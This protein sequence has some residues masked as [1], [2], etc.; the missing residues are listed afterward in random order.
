MISWASPLTLL[1][2]GCWML[3]DP[4][5]WPLH[6]LL[7]QICLCV[8][9]TARWDRGRLPDFTT[10][11]NK[12]ELQRSSVWLNG[13]WCCAAVTHHFPRASP[14]SL[15]SQSSDCDCISHA[16][17][18]STFSSID[19]CINWFP[20][21][22]THPLGHSKAGAQPKWQRIVHYRQTHTQIRY[23]YHGGDT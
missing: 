21:V 14:G 12:L 18:G 16:K 15:L 8:S 13:R 3:A 17:Q 4:S 7:T 23:L 10:G 6:L 5:F 20:R 19:L 11:I 1:A 2:L 22:C 9:W